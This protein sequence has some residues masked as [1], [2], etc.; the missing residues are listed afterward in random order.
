[1]GVWRVNDAVDAIHDLG[2]T[3]GSGPVVAEPD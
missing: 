1:M 2:A 3:H